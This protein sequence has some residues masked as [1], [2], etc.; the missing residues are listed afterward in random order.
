MNSPSEVRDF[1]VGIDYDSIDEDRGHF[2]IRRKV[3]MEELVE[4]LQGFVAAGHTYPQFPPEA[5]PEIVYAFDLSEKEDA[6]IY[7][8]INN[9]LIKSME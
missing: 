5:N 1:V 2:T 4:E 8:I 9:E 7:G 3:T 6:D